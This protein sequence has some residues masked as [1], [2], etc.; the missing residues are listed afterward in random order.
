MRRGKLTGV[1]GNLAPP[2]YGP[3]PGAIFSRK[4]GPP[5][6]NLAPPLQTWMLNNFVRVQCFVNVSILCQCINSTHVR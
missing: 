6:G 5:F 2:K 3:P 4:F 1:P